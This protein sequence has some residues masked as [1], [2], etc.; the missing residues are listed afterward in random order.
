MLAK[1]AGSII[2]SGSQTLA[3]N[4]SISIVGD[5]ITITSRHGSAYT[6]IR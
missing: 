2:V 1:R 4:E 5:I 3:C 6:S